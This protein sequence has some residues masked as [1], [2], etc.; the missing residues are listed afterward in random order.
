MVLFYFYFIVN[1]IVLQIS[2]DVNRIQSITQERTAKIIP[3][4]IKITTENES[5]SI[6]KTLPFFYLWSRGYFL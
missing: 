1:I 2:I 4:A 3:N 6:H 5:V